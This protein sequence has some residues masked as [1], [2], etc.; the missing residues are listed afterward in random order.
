MP[1]LTALPNAVVSAKQSIEPD[2][3]D[4]DRDCDP[5]VTTVISLLPFTLY[6]Y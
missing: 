4:G 2:R 6:E 5:V 1:T 3:Y